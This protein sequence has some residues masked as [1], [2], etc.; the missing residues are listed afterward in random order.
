MKTAH[1]EWRHECRERG[2]G[3]QYECYGAER[4]VR[5]VGRISVVHVEYVTFKV[6]THASYNDHYLSALV[7]PIESAKLGCSFDNKGGI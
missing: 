6:I 5:A 3:I 4:A 1:L 7:Q 2:D